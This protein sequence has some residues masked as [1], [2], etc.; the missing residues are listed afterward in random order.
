MKTVK[1]YSNILLLINVQNLNF[2]FKAS[3]FFTFCSIAFTLDGFCSLIFWNIFWAMQVLMLLLM[4]FLCQTDTIMVI[5]RLFSFTSGSRLQVPLRK[6]LQA[7]AGT[8][9]VYCG[10]HLSAL[11]H[12]LKKY[13]ALP[14][15]AYC[16]I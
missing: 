1:I 10:I 9:M 16:R 14:H 4:F 3:F 15:I 8:S 6:L 5:C 2:T 7:P 12:I 13:S 11:S